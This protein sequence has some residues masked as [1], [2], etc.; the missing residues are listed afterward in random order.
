MSLVNKNKYL[1]VKEKKVIKKYE[2]VAKKS[3]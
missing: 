2:K 3:G 1:Q